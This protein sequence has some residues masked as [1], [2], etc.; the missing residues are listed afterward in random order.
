MKYEKCTKCSAKL[1]ESDKFCPACGSSV[2]NI[3]KKCGFKTDLADRFCKNC[4]YKIKKNHKINF[5]KINW[6]SLYDALNFIA[7]SAS[8][9][10]IMILIS[11]TY[12]GIKE[13]NSQSSDSQKTYS[14]PDDYEYNSDSVTGTFENPV[15]E[16]YDQDRGNMSLINETREVL[17]EELMN[18]PSFKDLLYPPT[19][20]LL[21]Q[22]ILHGIE[23]TEKS[24]SE[25][26]QEFYEYSMKESN[27]KIQE[28]RKISQKA[29]F[30]TPTPT[31]ILTPTP[32]VPEYK[33]PIPN[34]MPTVAPTPTPDPSQIMEYRL[35][36]IE[37]MTKLIQDLTPPTDLNAKKLLINYYSQRADIHKSIY[38]SE[39]S[40]QD[41]IK[42]REIIDGLPD[43][44]DGQGDF[45]WTYRE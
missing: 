20:D 6:D 40:T 2:K 35:N 5:I 7:I 25:Y 21:N 39:S 32:Y 42:Y 22:R 12:I 18:D 30:S 45:C 19:K 29:M 43:L 4:G 11:Q 28:I 41:C 36:Q 33:T 14:L 17:L 27:E 13:N 16:K 9:F 38:K 31:F 24:I 3:C 1:L 34:S 37:N 26:Y 8:V 23:P 44:Y 15:A 10:V